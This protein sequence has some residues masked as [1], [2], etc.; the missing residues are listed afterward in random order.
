MNDIKNDWHRTDRTIRLG[1]VCT[2]CYHWQSSNFIIGVQVAFQ[3]N[4]PSTHRTKSSLEHPISYTHKYTYTFT[5]V[6]R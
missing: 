1:I 5:F 4:A 2:R 3:N 6:I